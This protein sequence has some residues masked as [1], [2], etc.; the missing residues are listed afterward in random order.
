MG[1]PRFPPR[2]KIELLLALAAAAGLLLLQL[3]APASANGG[4]W[5]HSA[6]SSSGG[7]S[8]PSSSPPSSERPTADNG[9]KG[10]F[11]STGDWRSGRATH[12]GG[13]ARG[14]G[15]GRTA[16]EGWLAGWRGVG[17]SASAIFLAWWDAGR[18]RWFMGDGDGWM[19]WGVARHAGTA[20]NAA[21]PM[22]YGARQ[23]RWPMLSAPPHRPPWTNPHPTPHP[24]GCAVPPSQAASR[25]GGQSMRSVARPVPLVG[26]V[27]A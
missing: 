14:G 15:A 2:P 10:G 6:S 22:C 11:T 21:P 4:W 1:G 19:G 13:C 24:S 26:L 5:G 17:G 20:G 9:W 12:Y 25:T 18:R 7:S 27:A 3:P 8:S 16:A 23:P